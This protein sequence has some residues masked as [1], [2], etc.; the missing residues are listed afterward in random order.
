[1]RA[2]K[3]VG[4]DFVVGLSPVVGSVDDGSGHGVCGVCGR[5]LHSIG[6]AQ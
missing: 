1:M 4:Q 6:T 3:V 2:G 5:A